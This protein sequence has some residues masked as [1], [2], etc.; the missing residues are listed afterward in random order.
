M[1]MHN[2]IDPNFFR[3]SNNRINVE[4][5]DT[6]LTIKLQEKSTCFE[7]PNANGNPFIMAINKGRVASDCP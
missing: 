4:N 2:K 6:R 5:Q 1:R 7:Y 3:I